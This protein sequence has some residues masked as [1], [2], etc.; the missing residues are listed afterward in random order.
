MR[1]YLEVIEG[2]YA[3]TAT[4]LVPGSVCHVG[5]R[6]GV[7]MFLPDP[8]LASVHYVLKGGKRG[9]E[10]QALGTVE[11]FVNGT[12]VRQATLQH[13]DWIV[14]GCSLFGYSEEGQLPVE[15]SYPSR[16]LLLHLQAQ[17]EALF[18]LVDTSLNAEVGQYLNDARNRDLHPCKSLAGA[19]VVGDHP[20][21]VQVPSDGQWLEWLIRNGWGKGWLTFLTSSQP[22]PFVYHHFRN[23]WL[24]TKGVGKGTG[25]RFYD[26]RVLRVLLP[27]CSHE[28]ATRMFGPVTKF[29]VESQLPHTGLEFDWSAAE[30]QATSI[31]LSLIKP[32]I[33]SHAQLQVYSSSVDLSKNWEETALAYLRQSFP[34]ETAGQVEDALRANVQQ[35]RFVSEQL[36]MQQLPARLQVALIGFLYGASIWQLPEMIACLQTPHYSSEEKLNRLVDWLNQGRG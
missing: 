8:T 12:A 17:R 2:R 1:A 31:R 36:G 21:L 5:S 7:D 26:P 6:L 15:S 18:V 29:I 16:Q 19:D 27:E 9:C 25:L 34:H 23:L 24:Q 4:S 10:M 13:G 28:Q 35:S 32:L 3:G 20:W 14:A 11:T 30:L 33:P 22:F